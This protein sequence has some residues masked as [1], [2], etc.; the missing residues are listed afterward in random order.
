LI[1]LKLL[2][3]ADLIPLWFSFCEIKGINWKKR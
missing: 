1:S 3:V 2:S